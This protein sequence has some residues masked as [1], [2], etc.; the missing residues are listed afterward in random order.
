MV[1]ALFIE[2]H[3]NDVAN[4]YLLHQHADSYRA[5]F[6][7]NEYYRKL[8]HS[9]I[10]VKEVRRRKTFLDQL[11][12]QFGEEFKGEYGW[13]SQALGKKNPRFA[14][15]EGSI[16]MSHWRP[17]YKLASQSVHAGPRAAYFSLGLMDDTN[18]LLSGPSN[19]G[20][21]DP[22][23]GVAL[24]LLQITALLLKMNSTIDSLAWMK[25]LAR[26]AP[27]VGE[28]FIQRQERLDELHRRHRK[29]EESTVS[30]DDYLSQ[31]RKKK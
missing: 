24:T 9:K 17:Y 2:E 26:M 6:Q 8:G 23:Q 5:A 29:A 10:P 4:R 30:L 16:Q 15:I 19:S 27:N 20:F 11:I 7:L 14:E 18:V 13:A 31:R 1:V 21:T 28:A 12:N 3:G 25:V 22:A